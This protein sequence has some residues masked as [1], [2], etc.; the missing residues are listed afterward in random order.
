MLSSMVTWL[1]KEVF[2][3]QPTCFVANKKP[4]YVCKLNK[5]LYGLKQVPQAWFHRL[6]QALLNLGFIG[7]L[8]DTSLFRLHS[9][10]LINSHFYFGLYGRCHS[11]GYR[12]VM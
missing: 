7:S 2:M 6:S 4:N 9:T 3:D 8:V 10:T 11:K 1:I 12:L 5:A